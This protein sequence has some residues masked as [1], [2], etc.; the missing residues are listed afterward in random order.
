MVITC[1][2]CASE[3]DLAEGGFCGVCGQQVDRVSVASGDE[4]AALEVA[5]FGGSTANPALAPPSPPPAS[6]SSPPREPV[7]AARPTGSPDQLGDLSVLGG[8]A[9]NATYL[10]Q[11][12]QY[13]RQAENLDISN[14]IAQATSLGPSIRQ[15]IPWLIL[16]GI[17]VLVIAYAVLG[18]SIGAIVGFAL[19]LAAL[20]IVI[21]PLLKRHYVVVSE[22]KLSLDGKG[23]VAPLVFDHIG[24]AVL[25]R[26][27]PVEYRALRLPDGV[28]YLNLRLVTFDA[29]ISCWPFGD[30]LY[31]GWTLWS[32]GTWS[33]YRVGFWRRFLAIVLLPYYIWLDVSESRR[34][35]SF[36][37]ANLHQSDA[38]KA[39][40]ECLHAVSREGVQAASGAVAFTGRGTIGSAIPTDGSF[41][42]RA[43]TLPEHDR[44]R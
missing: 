7:T 16:P 3:V 20:F 33:E 11:R 2:N 26:Q 37:V 19:V 43:M 5:V 24:A 17:P 38:L 23:S 40:R 25:R 44:R 22:W 34:R 36:D 31:I 41:A 4:T 6:S 35:Q 21:S 8:A 18:K 32:S 12:L 14:Q 28:T 30:D 29:Y 39:M 10:G 13:E 15:A 42:G 9:P 27:P 1:P